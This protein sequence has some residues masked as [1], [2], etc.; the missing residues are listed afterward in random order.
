M[1]G[2]I[3]RYKINYYSNKFV[4]KIKIEIGY[5]RFINGIFIVFCRLI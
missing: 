3:N 2:L 4:E 5:K 1:F